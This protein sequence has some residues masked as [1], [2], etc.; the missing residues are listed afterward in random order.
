MIRS[1]SKGAYLALVESGKVSTKRAQ[2]V[3]FVDDHPGCTRNEI[4]R[5]IPGMTVNCCCGR[6]R[7]LLD[8]G[9]LIEDGCKKDPVT[10]QSGNRLYVNR[11]EGDMA[12]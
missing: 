10:G 1:T 4:V 8:C 9:F 12:A 11:D 7:E 5:G 6:V 2:I 3:R